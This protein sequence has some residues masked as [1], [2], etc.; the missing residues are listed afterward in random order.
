MLRKILLV[1]IATLSSYSLTA[2]SGYILYVTL[3]GR[4]EAHLSL[5]VRF[6]LNPLIAILVGF[7]VGTLSKNYP[8]LTAVVGLAPWAVIVHGAGH[9]DTISGLTSWLLPVIVYGILASVAAIVGWRFR[10]RGRI[11]RGVARAGVTAL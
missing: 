5:L 9:P 1:V 4:S 11:G 3:S 2:L 7:V 6:V 10:Q 8:A